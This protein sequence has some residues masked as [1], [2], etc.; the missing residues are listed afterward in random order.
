VSQRRKPKVLV[1][2]DRYLPGVNAGGPVRS[3]ANLVQHLGNEVEFSIVTRDHDLGS[4]RPYANVVRDAWNKVGDAKVFYASGRRWFGIHRVVRATPHDVLYLSR[5]FSPWSVELVWMRKPG[6]LSTP[7][8]VVAPRGQFAPEALALKPIKKRAL[9]AAANI[10]RMHQGLVWHAANA[11]EV[12]QIRHVVRPE[13]PIIVAANLP[14][15]V[16]GGRQG[17]PKRPGALRVISVARVHPIKNILT[18][19][20]SFDGM[21]GQVQFDVLGPHEDVRYLDECRRAASALTGNIRVDFPGAVSHDEIARRLPEY[22]LFFLPT[23]GESFGHSIVEALAAGIPVLVSD[24]TPW[25][26]LEARGAG[27][28]L[29]LGATETFRNVL[30]RCVEMDESMH[31]RMAAAA[32]RTAQEFT[33]PLVADAIAG[34]RHLFA[35]TQ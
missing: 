15:A 30:A 21:A 13:G 27:W 5:Y 4:A 34:Y 1:V 28:D 22:D 12:E 20:R 2:L 11:A 6:T 8:C 9:I 25:R 33:R 7:R 26:G 3:I 29:P 31:A 16:G 18:A 32:R 23:L 10:A 35:L 19:I 14:S 17:A 24:Q